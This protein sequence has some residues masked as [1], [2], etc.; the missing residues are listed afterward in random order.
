MVGKQYLAERPAVRY[1]Q[2]L[3]V[4]MK[5]EVLGC[6][7][8]VT[9]R[10]GTTAFLIDDEMLFDAGTVTEVLS[11]ER[12]NRITYA[13]VTHIHLDHVK[14]L[15]SLAE[16]RSMGVDRSLT[17]LAV[18]E[19]IDDLSRHVFNNHLWPDFTLIPDAEKPAIR[20]QPIDVFEYTTAGRLRVK[21]IP[22]RHRIPTTG[23]LIK[24]VDK[25][26]ML[27]SDTGITKEFWETA[28]QEE[29]VDFIIAHVAFPSRLADL[30]QTAGHMTPSVLF[31]I[32]DEFGLGKTPFYIA[33]MKSMCESEI[34]GE[35]MAAGR[36][37][38][39]I[40]E[41]GVVLVP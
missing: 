36:P 29:H 11:P 37:N 19:V 5:I 31:D 4:I 18:A 28:R 35:I 7:G 23:F 39:R 21:P 2:C 16:H 3:K 27:T 40:L 41:Q 10:R 13:C 20:L 34:R 17:I 25:T 8:N 33:H 32:I 9:G 38:I 26:I 22:V 30:A 1:P 15:C 6:Y 14:G 12:L 24:D